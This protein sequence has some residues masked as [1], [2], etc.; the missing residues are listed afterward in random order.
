MA[1]CKNSSIMEYHSK[2]LVSNICHYLHQKIYRC[3]HSE[4]NSPSS[5]QTTTST[6]KVSIK[7]WQNINEELLKI[8]SLV[9]YFG[10]FT[11]E[12]FDM[13]LHD[14]N[15]K[16]SKILVEFYKVFNF[17]TFLIYVLPKFNWN[18]ISASCYLYFGIGNLTQIVYNGKFFNVSNEVNVTYVR[19]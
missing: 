6:Y 12:C 1:G 18:L 4:W 14:W 10:N 7:F 5:I 13:W 11:Q 15:G 17:E 3:K 2:F 16:V 19:H 8:I 9:H